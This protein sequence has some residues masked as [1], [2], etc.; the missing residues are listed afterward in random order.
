MA[1]FKISEKIARPDFSKI[2]VRQFTSN[3][4]KN[5]ISNWLHSALTD[6]FMI[7]FIILWVVPLVLITGYSI[8]NFNSLPDQIPLFYSRKWG[9]GQ[10]AARGYVFVPVAGSFLLGIFN[11]CLGINFHPS[12]KVL[13]YLFAGT[14]VI[15]SALT[16]I[17]TFN[18]INLIK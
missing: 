8:F 12:E 4:T 1:K 10:L 9:E 3:Q 7:G 16:A 6:N 18:I 17:T 15:I 5:Q 2:G 11:F 13:S 14:A